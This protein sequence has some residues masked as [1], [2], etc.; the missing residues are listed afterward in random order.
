MVQEISRK[1]KFLEIF[2]DR[3]KN[4]LISNQLTIVIVEKITLEEEPDVS[5]FPEIPK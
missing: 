2:Q 1:K 3:C 4:D 5:M